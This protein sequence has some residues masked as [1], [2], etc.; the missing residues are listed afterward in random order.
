MI[1]S[2]ARG[3]SGCASAH[4]N[5]RG[6][7]VER[8]ARWL[9]SAHDRVDG[10]ALFF[11]HDMLA[12]MLA[13]RRVGVTNAVHVL[14]GR[15]QIRAFRG[16]IQVL[17]RAALIESANGLYVQD[18]ELHRDQGSSTKDTWGEPEQEL[19]KQRASSS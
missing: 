16:N 2:S 15:R 5:A 8:L 9:L 11:T 4:A 12:A 14:E 18:H 6:V 17:D 3:S 1:A 19:P 10:E 7:I 13:V